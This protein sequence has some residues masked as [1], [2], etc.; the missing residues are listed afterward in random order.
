MLLPVK[1]VLDKHSISPQS[2]SRLLQRSSRKSIPT[3]LRGHSSCL[4]RKSIESEGTDQPP[5]C[6]DILSPRPDQVQRHSLIRVQVLFSVFG[7]FGL[8]LEYFP[9]VQTFVCYQ[10]ETDFHEA[11]AQTKFVL[12]TSY[13]THHRPPH[14]TL[15][16]STTSPIS[17]IYRLVAA[18]R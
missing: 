7:L 12:H 4:R 5:S 13:N 8:D 14:N 18:E 6:A 11:P 16:A 10:R 3:N 17:I 15:P 1:L 9:G 2:I